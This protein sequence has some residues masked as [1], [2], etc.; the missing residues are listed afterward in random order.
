[1][2]KDQKH[3]Y[4]SDPAIKQNYKL[5]EELG[6]G[7]FGTVVKA[8]DRKTG[9][10]VAIKL[11]KDVSKSSYSLRKLLRE[12]IILRKLSEIENNIFTTKLLDI[13]I[14]NSSYNDLKKKNSDNAT[15]ISRPV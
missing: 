15:M 7:S 14:P 4:W 10:K 11:M 1:M 8:K 5:L 13:I 2:E 3:S 9:Q 12:I 6:K